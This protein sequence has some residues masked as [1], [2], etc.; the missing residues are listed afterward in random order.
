MATFSLKYPTESSPTA[1][2][3]P[4]LDPIMESGF[5]DDDNMIVHTMADGKTTYNYR[6]GSSVRSRVYTFTGLT[7]A[8][9]T[10]FETFQAAA[11]GET[12]KVIDEVSTPSYVTVRFAPD[13]FARAWRQMPKS[14]WGLVLKLR[15]E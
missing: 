15:E 2:W 11:L 9:R 14:K 13:G 10:S 7:N 6:R 1:T 12:F 4:S 8:D 5:E 3:A